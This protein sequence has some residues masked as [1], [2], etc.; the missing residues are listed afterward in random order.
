[1]QNKLDQSKSV[2]IYVLQN[3]KFKMALYGNEKQAIKY[4][5]SFKGALL[6]IQYYLL[7]PYSM[8]LR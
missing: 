1:M 4:K 8:T 3:E 6:E 2:Y 7:L 5:V